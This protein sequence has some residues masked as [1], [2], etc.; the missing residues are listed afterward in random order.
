MRLHDRDHALLRA[1]AGGG[2][3]GADLGRMMGIIVDDDRAIGFAHPGETTLDALE[4][5]ESGNDCIV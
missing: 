4:P 1:L 2:E 3:H 5:F